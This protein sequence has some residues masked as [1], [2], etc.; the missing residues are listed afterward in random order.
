MEPGSY[1]VFYRAQTQIE[2]NYW[3][4]DTVRI[5]NQ[6]GAEI[7]LV[8]NKDVALALRQRG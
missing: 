6:A 1:V 7:M 2:F 8:K 5:T 4:G 3:E